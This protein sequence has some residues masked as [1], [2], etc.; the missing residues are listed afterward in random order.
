ALT[1]CDPAADPGPFPGPSAWG[2]RHGPGG[3]ARSFDA[4]ELYTNCAY[5][6]GGNDD[7]DHHNLVVPFDGYL[8][9]PWAP[10]WG[11][12]GLALFDVSDPCAPV[13]VGSAF[14]RR[15]RESHSIGFS[16]I[17]G[18]FAVVDQITGALVGGGIQFWDLADPTSPAPIAD[19]ELPGFLYPDAYARVTISVF[20]QAPY[21]FVAGS[22]N[23]VY[24]VDATD[25]RAPAHVA[26]YR[27]DPVLRVGQVQVIGNLLVATAAEGPRTVLLDVSRPTDPQPIAGGDFSAVDATGAA[28]EAYFTNMQGGYVYYARK[29][30]GGGLMI[31][32][33][34]DPSAPLYA[35]DLRSPDGNGGY[36]FVH[37]GYA[38][39]GESHFATIYDVRDPSSITEVARLNLVGDL[40]TI[41]PVGNVAVLSVDDESVVDQASSVA[42]WAT[43]PD[44]RAPRVGWSWPAEGA[45][46]LATTSRIGVSLDEMIEPLSAFEG[47]VRLYRTSAGPGSGRVPA[48]ISAQEH[49]VNVHPRCPLAPSTD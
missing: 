37:H 21:V 30:N 33:I 11:G 17:G 12:G 5:L 19:L 6:S 20:W 31:M 8:L 48:V 18:R 35:G 38:F 15:M 7:A 25:P 49:L 29:S 13:R 26:T 16:T 28:V 2:P 1:L 45:I 46:D 36:V 40:D 44:A 14:S 32:D 43:E 47:S 41:T 34:H 24:V 3:P 10:E 23:G 42:P 22:D 39:V 27:F 9:M 4:S